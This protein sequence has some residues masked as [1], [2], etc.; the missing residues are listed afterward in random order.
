[1]YGSFDPVGEFLKPFVT[2]PNR[3]LISTE[4]DRDENGREAVAKSKSEEGTS[5]AVAIRESGFGG[6]PSPR[7]GDRCGQ[8][9]ALRGR[10]TGS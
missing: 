5:A 2:G 3:I 8:W 6:G 4:E 1:M 9:S 10:E 7:R